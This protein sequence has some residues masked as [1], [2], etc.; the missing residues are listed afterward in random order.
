MAN[1]NEPEMNFNSTHFL[2][3]PLPA[4]MESEKVILGAILIDQ[5]LIYEVIDQGLLEE[6]FYS[7]NNKKI[8]R[9][10]CLLANNHGMEINPITIVEQFKL[11]GEDANHFGGLSAISN[12]MIGIPSFNSLTQYVVILINKSRT[13]ELIRSCG[14]IITRAL[15]EEDTTDELIEHSESS[16]FSIADAVQN[17][18]FISTAET[19]EQ[20]IQRAEMMQSSDKKIVGLSTGFTDVDEKTLGFQ[21]QHLIY[22]G[23]R[24]SMGKTALTMGFAANVAIGSESPVAVFSLEMNKEELTDR[25]ICA[26]A[27]I[28]SLNYKLGNLSN[29][30]WAKIHEA[31]ARV[32][33]APLFIN[34]KPGIG[35]TYIRSKL[36][37]LK[38]QL[39]HKQLGLIVVDYIGL[40]TSDSLKKYES[41][42]QEISVIS[43]NMKQIAK[44]FDVP[45]IVVSQLNRGPENRAQDNHRPT[46][47][48]FRE[49][50]SIEQDA[51]VVMLV[52]RADYYKKTPD[53]LDTNTAE[54]IIGKNRNGP[55]GTVE[56]RFDKPSTKF[57]SLVSNF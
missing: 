10:M 52:Y 45:V 18:E 16:I 11:M 40:M 54:I 22:V 19:V 27:E 6:H 37:R 29:Q 35:V 51:D 41:R 15:N 49:S 8:Y 12:L 21:K 28:D 36:R 56:L 48:D 31:S 53:V 4:S 1:N 57:R 20:S 3:K 47:A 13:R 14:E 23:G 39:G 55:T 25:F 32:K 17:T 26:E 2:E 30:E 33:A 42:Q 50:G 7:P 38:K 46:M 44:E 34:D 24:P 43:A 9:A 5:N